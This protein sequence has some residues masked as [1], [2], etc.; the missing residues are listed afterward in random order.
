[1][2]LLTT[3]GVVRVDPIHRI[4]VELSRVDH[5]EKNLTEIK[6]CINDFVAAVNSG[7][8][9]K[10]EHELFL[11][12]HLDSAVLKNLGDVHGQHDP[13]FVKAK[14]LLMVVRQ[15]LKNEV[16]LK[17]N[18]HVKEL[19]DHLILLEND[20]YVHEL[21]FGKQEH[22]MLS[23]LRTLLSQDSL[24]E[25]Q[26]KSFF[27]SFGWADY[28]L[29]KKL[30]AR[31]GVNKN[32]INSIRTA[33][34]NKVFREEYDHVSKGPAEN[35]EGRA[36]CRVVFIVKKGREPHDLDELREFYKQATSGHRFSI[37]VEY[38]PIQ[39]D[40]GKKDVRDCEGEIKNK[41]RIH[42]FRFTIPGWG[43]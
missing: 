43:S 15:Y 1:M 36:K 16:S 23:D 40:L 34:E 2:G 31:K 27:S 25:G 7:K 14:A 5:I 37:D 19:V 35:P 9:K 18:P 21:R 12:Q 30:S 42:K 28:R 11:V 20:L 6:R 38:L 33:L 22:Q 4:E 41:H 13:A 8:I 17:D 32:T 26:V 10:A 29:G 24:S 3:L 39:H